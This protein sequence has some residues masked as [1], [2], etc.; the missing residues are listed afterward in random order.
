MERRTADFAIKADTSNKKDMSTYE[1]TKESVVLNCAVNEFLKYGYIK[2]SLRVIAKEAGVTTGF[3]YSHYQSKHELFKCLVDEVYCEVIQI[4]AK[5]LE[6]IGVTTSELPAYEQYYRRVIPRLF[7]YIVHKRKEIKLLTKCSDG[8]EY[9]NFLSS[10]LS[11]EK[12]YISVLWPSRF[13]E[14]PYSK[15]LIQTVS[16]SFYMT[17][18]ELALEGNAGNRNIHYTK[19]LISF[20]IGGWHKI[21]Q[22]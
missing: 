12:E 2:A 21:F 9:R 6:E 15:D 20:F 7:D 19:Y 11:I 1:N 4:V 5:S 13:N 16:Y 17:V 10:L 22:Y 8:T 3:I 14:K 18:F